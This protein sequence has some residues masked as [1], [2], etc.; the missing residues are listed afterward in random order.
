MKKRGDK[1][2]GGSVSLRTCYEVGSKYQKA[3]ENYFQSKRDNLHNISADIIDIIYISWS[4]K[5]FSK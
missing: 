2:A 5:V 1:K 3:L 4:Q